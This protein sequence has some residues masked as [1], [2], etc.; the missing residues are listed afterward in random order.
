MDSRNA[1]KF[2]FVRLNSSESTSD[3]NHELAEIG[4]GI[5]M[6]QRVRQ[7]QAN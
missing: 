3:I 2:D 4:F 7:V 5:S 6:N 1:E